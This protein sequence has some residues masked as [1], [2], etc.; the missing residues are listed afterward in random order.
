MRQ[1]DRVMLKVVFGL[2]HEEQLKAWQIMINMNVTIDK[3]AKNV[4][5]DRK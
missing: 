1:S 2:N 5:K 3:A 4:I